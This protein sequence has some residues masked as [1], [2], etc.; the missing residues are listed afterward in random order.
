VIL[1]YSV[2]CQVKV[3]NE[4]RMERRRYDLN[5]DFPAALFKR[6]RRVVA[7]S[8]SRPS[9]TNSSECGNERSKLFIENRPL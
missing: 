2:L 7:A 8:A 6:R 1:L 4:K 9:T 3:S 5:R